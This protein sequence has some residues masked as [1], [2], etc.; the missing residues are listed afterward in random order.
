ML[1]VFVVA[2]GSG[3]D[4]SF[5]MGCSSSSSSSSSLSLPFSVELS[6]P[7]EEL[8][9][10]TSSTNVDSSSSS[11]SELSTT[12]SS[13]LC[14]FF[15]AGFGF[16]LDLGRDA[17][18]ADLGF[19][20]VGVWDDIFGGFVVLGGAVGGLRLGKSLPRVFFSMVVQ[21][22]GLGWFGRC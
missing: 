17:F 2:I 10:V 3:T 20:V 9:V 1:G 16:C 13:D 4:E 22:R 7:L 12:R 21:G 11:S 14:N 18:G 8:E 19:L 5:A 15:S 6:P